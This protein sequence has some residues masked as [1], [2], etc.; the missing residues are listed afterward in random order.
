MNKKIGI[1]I[2]CYNVKNSIAKVLESF[3]AETIDKVSVF[4]IVENKSMDQ[5]LEVVRG[6][7]VA[8][9]PSSSLAKKLTIIANHE[10]Y[11]LG[12][13]QKI[14]YSYFLSNGFSHFMIIHGDNQGNAE[15]IAQNFLRELELHPDT[16]FIAASRF[17]KS[18]DTSR[19]SLL[20]TV[21]NKFF[22]WLTYVLSGVRM[23][24]SGCG[25]VLIKTAILRDIPFHLFNNS[26][27]FNP[28]LNIAIYSNTNNKISEI[29]IQ[30]K[31]A[32][33]GSSIRAFRYCWTLFEI[34]LRYFYCHRIRGLPI[35][36]SL[37]RSENLQKFEYTIYDTKN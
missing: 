31:D 30:W 16:D 1:Y 18:S 35:V 7:Q 9:G 36:E 14:A 20:R 12:G 34:L 28:Q 2:P 6:F 23:S 17:L 8:S 15:T 26:A 4:L 37:G 5:T 21:A 11:G 19:Y 32:L 27:Q 22:N 3:S 25:I 10:N 24:D 33:E 29:P 13:S